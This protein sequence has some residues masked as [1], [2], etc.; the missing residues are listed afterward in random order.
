[1]SHKR[2]LKPKFTQKQKELLKAFNDRRITEILYGGGARG[3]KSWGVCEI[4]NITCIAQP[5]IVWLV[6]RSEWDDLRKTTLATLIKV[7]NKHGM[8]QDREYNINFQTKELT[9][10][11]G[12][13]ILF[14]PLKQQPSDT[15]FN[16]LGS[17]EITYGFIDEAQQVVR[18]A[19]DIILSRC[20][21]KIKEYDLVGKI[22]MTCNPMKCHLYNDFIKPQRDG[23]L[24]ADRI[25]IS[26]LYKDNPFI[27]HKKYEQSLKRA[28]KITKERLLNGNW[29]YDD[30]PT[31]LYEYDDICD[32]FTNHGESGQHYITC[33]IA[34]LG[35]D[36]TVAIVWDGWIGR[37]FSYKKKRTTETA[38]VLQGLQQQYKV[39]N[40][41]TICDEDG[42]GGGVV[43]QLGCKGF[44]NNSSPILTPEE[45]Q[46]RNYKNMKDQCYFELQ[47][48][49]ESGKM[50]LI[51]MNSDDKEL[52]I[53]E[54]DV[55]KQKNPDKGGKLQILSKEEVKLLIGRSPDF[56]DTIAMR[57]RFELNRTPEVA[58]YFI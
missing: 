29:D 2:I 52:I 50:Q 22:I 25:F 41:D 43:D 24:P 12:S 21:E 14:V 20:T 31:K 13:K 23:T 11:N 53:E 15:E 33:D 49:I 42:V 19:I 3:G 27:D 46:I 4:I 56:S 32:L 40:S 38:K 48:I 58:I 34:R 7:L 26:S 47:Q 28:D 44:V 17:Y 55:V 37:I 5:G 16:W 36:H 51:V 35:N 30:D 45:K 18:K 1:M 54:L 8:Q 57:M 6:G 9:Y 10:Y 39:K